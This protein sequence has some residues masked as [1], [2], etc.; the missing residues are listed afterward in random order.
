MR[1]CNA[2]CQKLHWSAHKNFCKQLR[3]QYE[4]QLRQQ[5]LEKEREEQAKK[6]REAEQLAEENVDEGGDDSTESQENVEEANEQTVTRDMGGV[7]LEDDS[8][9]SNTTVPVDS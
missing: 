8:N 4:A 7:T 2:A 6:E 1:Y 9:D 5:K 3:L